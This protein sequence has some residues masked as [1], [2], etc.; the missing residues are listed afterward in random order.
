MGS[1]REDLMSK[2]YLAT[3]KEEI[4]GLIPSNGVK[5]KNNLEGFEVFD[6]EECECHLNWLIELK[7]QSK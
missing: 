6:G 5:R 3:M 2:P 7:A 4:N 1:F